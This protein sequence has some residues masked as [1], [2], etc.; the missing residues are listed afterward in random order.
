MAAVTSLRA[1]VQTLS[2]TPVKELPPNIEY[3]I[4]AIGNCGSILSA[5]ALQKQTEGGSDAVLVQRLKARITS[6][7]QDRTPEARVTGVILVKSIIEAGQWEIL[8]GCE[9]WVRAILA[10][11]GKPESLSSKKL[12]VLTITR[13]F[14][15]TRDYP[16]LIREITTP[17]LPQFISSCLNLIS[18]RLGSVTERKLR[19]DNPLIG[20]VFSSFSL[21]LPNHPTI[22]RPFSSQI[23][24][25][26]LP[27]I[28]GPNSQTPLSPSTVF[29]AQQLFISLH[30]CA[31]KN[32]S[33]DEWTKAFRSTVQSAH[34]TA[35]H[36]FRAVREQWESV[37]PALRQSKNTIGYNGIVGDD[38]PDP[39]G[40][41]GWTGIYQGCDRL[42]GLLR[43]LSK[44]FSFR[45]HST[46]PIPVGSVMDLLARLTSLTV[47][48]SG[49]TSGIVN[50]EVDRNEREAL[51]SVLPVIHAASL[52]VYQTILDLIGTQSF[53]L[54]NSC[55]DQAIWV[56]G[57]SS[58]DPMVK[59]ATYRSVSNI[60]SIIGPSMPKSSVLSLSQV[61]QQACSDLLPTIDHDIKANAH[62]AG[63]KTKGG[64]G[65]ANADSFL[66]NKPKSLSSRSISLDSRATIASASDLLLKVLTYVPTEL[67]PLS[68]RAKIDRTAVL[69]ASESLLMA[70][71]LNPI[72]S[73]GSNRGHPSI[74]PFLAKCQPAALEVEGLLRPRMPVI[75]SGART[76]KL[77]FE[78][79]EDENESSP[80]THILDIQSLQHNLGA[81][82]SNETGTADVQEPRLTP[83][84]KRRHQMENANGIEIQPPEIIGGPP[85]DK[86]PR[87]ENEIPNT[88]TAYQPSDQI[89]NELR[90]S[91]TGAAPTAYPLNPPVV[92]TPTAQTHSESLELSQVTTEVE[93]ATSPNISSI[94]EIQQ[95]GL[96]GDNASDSD[97]EIPQLN[98]EPD[99]DDDEE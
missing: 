47:P 5:P 6:L 4:R 89:L 68:I 79:S 40:L 65:T 70:S 52:D 48:G 37:D 35:D 96:S 11:L 71:T 84:N 73:S 53:S 99:T 30:H 43:L 80:N 26:L 24:A 27:S 76:T 55:L 62:E 90:E 60:L 7:L 93:M 44:F 75:Y 46:V 31:P 13:I 58:F 25:L 15:L 36:L 33:A 56:F 91:R 51:W 64:N 49:D 1:V 23:V 87:V 83:G 41:S 95:S 61:I 16:T 20:P 3:L 17:L 66:G 34:R 86:R 78:M 32:T 92:A 59:I 54:T 85:P 74:M 19:N 18:I 21:L 67:I 72:P 97:D 82:R 63:R 39:L 69:S 42:V 81:T 38:G 98:M 77:E 14:Q 8:R 45:S 22:F 29:V 2:T 12:C 94:P 9:P 28:T 50:P 88:S 10:I 57:S